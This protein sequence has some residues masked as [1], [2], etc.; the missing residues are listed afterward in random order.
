MSN[1]TIVAVNDTLRKSVR[2]IRKE[3]RV[4]R[5]SHQIIKGI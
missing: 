4:K 3:W 1:V 5:L 2:I